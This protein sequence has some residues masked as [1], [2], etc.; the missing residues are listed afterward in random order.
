MTPGPGLDLAIG[1]AAAVIATK[2][3]GSA[4]ELAI[5]LPAAVS[6]E[7]RHQIVERTGSRDRA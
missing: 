5:Y 4:I 6:V 1:L 2:L 7:H 3:R